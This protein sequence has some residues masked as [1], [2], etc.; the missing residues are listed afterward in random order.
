MTLI[1][2]SSV[3]QPINKFIKISDNRFIVNNGA[4]VLSFLDMCDVKLNY[5]Q[6]L[7]T[8]IIIPAGQTD[9]IVSFPAMGIKTTFLVIKPLYSVNSTNNNFIK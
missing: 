1:K 6:Y 2:N 7:R 9:F 8:Q 5:E 4:N 3:F